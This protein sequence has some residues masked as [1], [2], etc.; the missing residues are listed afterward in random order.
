MSTLPSA[1]LELTMF[2]DALNVAHLK[3]LSHRWDR[4]E[5]GLSCCIYSDLLLLIWIHFFFFFRYVI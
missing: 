5:N 1:L 4:Y 3:T 2:G